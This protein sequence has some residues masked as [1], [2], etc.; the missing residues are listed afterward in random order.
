MQTK[1]PPTKRDSCGTYSGWNKHTKAKETQ[2]EECRSFKIEYDKKYAANP[3]NQERIRERDR[4]RTRNPDERAKALAKYRKK[5]S[6]KERMR[7]FAR[8]RRALKRNNGQQAYSEFQ[9]LELYGTNCHLCNLPID[10]QAPRSTGE[11]G[12]QSGLHIDHVIP[13]SQGGP[14][15]LSNVRPAHGLCNISRGTNPVNPIERQQMSDDTTTPVADASTAPADAT[16]VDTTAAPAAD[17]TAT[18]ATTAPAADATDAP[19]ADA[20]VADAPV[21]DDATADDSDAD[22]AEDED[23]EDIDFDDFDDEDDEDEDEDDAE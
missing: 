22:D 18:D 9:V 13:I 3:K 11:Q 2:C 14:D 12:W 20:P 1:E 4:L 23:D 15:T 19:V 21:A 6:T 7:S 8:K 16:A 5:D 10:L 17:A